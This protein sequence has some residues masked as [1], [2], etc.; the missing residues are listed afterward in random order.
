MLL[1]GAP[2]VPAPLHTTHVLNSRLQPLWLRGFEPFILD[3]PRFS[4]LFLA[5]S[6]FFSGENFD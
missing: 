5:F 2:D 1:V 3:F 4:S 6:R